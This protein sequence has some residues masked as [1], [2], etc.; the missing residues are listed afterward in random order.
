MT[1][2]TSCHGGGAEGSKL[3]DYCRHRQGPAGHGCKSS[4]KHKAAGKASFDGPKDHEA[5]GEGGP[6]TGEPRD[7]Q[8]AASDPGHP[9]NH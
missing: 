3:S 9:R 7:R 5:P 6:R 4:K 1:A 8:A 2:R